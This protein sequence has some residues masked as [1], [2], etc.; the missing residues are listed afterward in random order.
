MAIINP[1]ECTKYAPGH[2]VHYIQARVKGGSQRY[3]CRVKYLGPDTV[4]IE[5]EGTSVTRKHHNAIALCFAA[6]QAV[7]QEI[8]YSPEAELLWVKSEKATEEHSGS[9]GVYYLAEG[10]LEG[11]QSTAEPFTKSVALP[12]LDS[13]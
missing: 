13:K 1:L 8:H 7:D 5:Y 6:L 3:P 4:R 2:L 12:R 10:E 11:C 9:W